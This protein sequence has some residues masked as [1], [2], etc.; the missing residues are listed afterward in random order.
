MPMNPPPKV[1]RNRVDKVLLPG[2]EAMRLHVIK[3]ANF[4]FEGS[5]F[6]DPLRRNFVEAM[7]HSY[8][9]I[10][11]VSFLYYERKLPR[12]MLPFV[13][14][15]GGKGEQLFMQAKHFPHQSKFLEWYRSK[16]SKYA[17]MREILS[18]M[19]G[20]NMPGQEAG[21]GGEILTTGDT[22]GGIT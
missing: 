15:W 5:D 4:Y 8:P 13:V 6:F 1:K 2:Y 11:L 12:Q 19:A 3:N 17:G 16:T 9:S 14:E 21:A 10:P 20:K 7:G 18:E 22:K